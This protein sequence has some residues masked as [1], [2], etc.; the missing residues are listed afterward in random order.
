MDLS[1][2]SFKQLR[3]D[4]LPSLPHTH[5]IEQQHVWLPHAHGGKHNARLL[6]IRQLLDEAGLHLA[7]DAKA[8]QE[9]TPLVNIPHEAAGCI[10]GVGGLHTQEEACDLHLSSSLRPL[11]TD[12][13]KKVRGVT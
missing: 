6:P 4:P 10:V 9:G 13:L 11:H 1:C 7:T 8:A 12:V 3:F 5:L 2:I